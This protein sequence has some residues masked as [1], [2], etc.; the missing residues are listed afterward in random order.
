MAIF[1]R[2]FKFCMNLFKKKS[3][4]EFE[5]EYCPEKHIGI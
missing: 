5:D 3:K 4:H 1:K 2:L